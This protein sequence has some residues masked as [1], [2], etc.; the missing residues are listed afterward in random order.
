MKIPCETK[1]ARSTGRETMDR[2]S[3]SLRGLYDPRRSHGFYVPVVCPSRVRA[4][5]SGLVGR[6]EGSSA[7]P[8]AS[9]AAVRSITGQKS[10]PKVP[11]ERRKSRFA[12]EPYSAAHVSPGP[13]FTPGPNVALALLSPGPEPRRRSAANNRHLGSQSRRNSRFRGCQ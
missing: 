6:L 8:R 1:L 10:G 7:G 3:S 11:W 2:S 9:A 5:T 13:P 4:R 12:R